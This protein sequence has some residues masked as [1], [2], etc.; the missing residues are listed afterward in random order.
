M[1]DVS[2]YSPHMETLSDL[3]EL[4]KK[5]DCK[6]SFGFSSSNDREMDEELLAMIGL[7]EEMLSEMKD[8]MTISFS[9]SVF[10]KLWFELSDNRDHTYHT[11]AYIE[12]STTIEVECASGFSFY[13][14]SEQLFDCLREND[15]SCNGDTYF[16]S[17]RY[18]PTVIC[19]FGYDKMVEDF[20][21]YRS[22][23][24]LHYFA[25]LVCDYLH[26]PKIDRVY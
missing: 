6:I 19:G 12:R 9:E 1:M 17:K 20:R 13:S 5:H 18:N 23:M 2:F 15:V 16:I 7:S 21:V 24:A 8:K 10:D 26:E 14:V 22:G 25:N 3:M 11:L 4:A